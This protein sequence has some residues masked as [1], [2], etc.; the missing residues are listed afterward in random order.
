MIE[1][2]STLSVP[3]LNPFTPTSGIEP[4]RF[5]DR[6]EEV[7]TFLGVLDKAKLGRCEHFI[8]VGPWG[9]GKTVLLKEFKNIAQ[10]RNVPAALVSASSF[11]SRD[12]ELDGVRDV[13]QQLASGF[14]VELGRLERFYNLMES[15]GVEIV[16]FGVNFT[17][18][19][20]ELSPRMLLE[21]SLLRLWSDLS[22][23]SD[24]VLILIDDVQNWSAI[25]TIFTTL[26]NVLSGEKVVKGTRVIVGLACTPDAWSRFMLR[27]HPI[28][29]YFVPRMNLG[30]LSKEDTIRFI[31]TLLE[32][33]G[34]SFAKEIKERVFEHAQGHL[35]ETHMLC[36]MLYNNQIKEKV[37]EA[38]WESSLNQA[39][40]ELG[41]RVFES[42]YDKA[43]KIERQV[44]YE[45]AKEEK[46]IA[47]T[48]FSKKIGKTL[49]DV[50][51]PLNRLVNKNLVDKPR[52]GEYFV[53]DKLFREYVLKISKAG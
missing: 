21:E 31:D 26:R 7:R 14:P 25:H 18:E 4:K 46:P 40:S 3:E 2:K 36:S 38:V 34:V 20:K 6:D 23:S 44:L 35:Y 45:M 43:S 29:R 10:R 5:V 51:K 12:R 39:L 17:K 27:D 22:K 24:A 41:E 28:G 9:S 47:I 53:S 32:G 37:A 8:V 15:I 50:S 1:M 30:K 52:R 19:S 13:V 16:G 11:T 49:D 42:F 48:D 33:T